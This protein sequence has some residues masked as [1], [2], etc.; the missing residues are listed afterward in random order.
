MPV[1]VDTNILLR[2]RD[3]N[4]AGHKECVALLLQLH[5]RVQHPLV[6]C[7]QVLLEFWS[8]AT[9]PPEVNGLGLSAAE[10]EGRLDDLT[11]VLPC[12]PEP[13]DIAALWRAVVRVTP[14]TGK[15][16]HD[17][18][19]VAFMHAHGID[20]IITLNPKH[21]SRFPGVTCYSPTDAI[22]LKLVDRPS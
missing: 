9:R 14:V 22:A 7:A 21:L 17:A 11:R 19:L 6:V 15:Q 16:V 4:S 3:A 13:P 10:T 12:L 1:L 20:E 5:N 8:V 18:R 2:T